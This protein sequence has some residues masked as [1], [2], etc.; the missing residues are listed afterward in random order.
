M[1]TYDGSTETLSIELAVV[2]VRL[3]ATTEQPRYRNPGYED[4]DAKQAGEVASLLTMVR[5]VS[6]FERAAS[7]TDFPHDIPIL[8]TAHDFDIVRRFN[9]DRTS[10]VCRARNGLPTCL[11]SAR[12]IATVRNVKIG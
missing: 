6:L 9:T 7:L 3:S 5:F 12:T 4:S 1:Y 8:A 10:G 2:D 11:G